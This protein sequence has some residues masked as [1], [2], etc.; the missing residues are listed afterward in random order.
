MKT[1]IIVPAYNED[2]N[3]IN[4]IKKINQTVNALIIII[5]DSQ[6]FKTKN[7]FKKKKKN[8]LYFHRGKKLGRGSAVIYGLKKAL[9]IKNFLHFIEIDA[10]MSHR[11]YE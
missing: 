11:P 10:D 1:V 5:D 6:N 7:L 2:Q 9:K 4:L 8:I 3:L